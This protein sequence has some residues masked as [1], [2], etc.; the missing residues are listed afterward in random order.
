MHEDDLDQLAAALPHLT[1]A[2]QAEALALLEA[3]KADRMIKDMP[4]DALDALLAI[5]GSIQLARGAESA[6][7][8]PHATDTA[9]IHDATGRPLPYEQWRDRRTGVAD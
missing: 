4:D 1:P 5:C 9:I 2:E 3:D 7:L 8:S 6:P